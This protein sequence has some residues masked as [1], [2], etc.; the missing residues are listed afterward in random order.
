MKRLLLGI[1][2]LSFSA[3]DAQD[4]PLFSQKLTNSFIYNPAMAGHTFGS[5]TFSYRTNYSGVADAPK[6]YFLSLH[7]PFANGRFGTGFNIYQEEVGIIRNTYYSGA[8][9]Y[10]LSFNK[11]SSLS[12]GISGEY[13]KL[14]A[15]YNAVT[16]PY[17][18]SDPLIASLNGKPDFSTGLLYQ[19]RFIKAGFAVNRLASTWLQSRD[20]KRL[21]NFYSGTLQG[22]IPLREGADLLEPYFAFQKFSG[23]N[24]TFNLGLYYTYDNLVTIGAAG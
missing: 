4:I 14:Q 19:N 23:S 2:V 3:A 7:T 1:F 20:N 21:T 24:N 9:S 17:I 11:F 10:H 5:A 12:M 22:M 18:A 6:D 8:F 13:N 15:S 16:D